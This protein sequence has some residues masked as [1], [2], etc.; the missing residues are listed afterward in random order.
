MIFYFS[1]TGNSEYVAKLIGERTGEEVINIADCV[2]KTKYHFIL[3]KGERVGFVYPVYCWGLP[4]IVK[5]FVKEVSIVKYGKHFVYSV[6]T[7]GAAT[8]SADE[9]LAKLLKAKK[10]G[11]NA[12]FGIKM[13]DNYTVAFSVKNKEKINAKNLKAMDSI[14]DMLFLVDNK[15]GGYYNHCR[16]F[17]PAAHVAHLS[18][19]IGRS[20][21]PFKASQDCIGCGKCAKGCPTQAISIELGKPV[22]KKKSCTMCLS[23]LHHCPVNAI[24]YGP[25]TKFN[26]QYVFEE[27]KCAIDEVENKQNEE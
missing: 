5:D 11:M 1:G 22:W 24:N 25:T 3:K 10:I 18:Y 27:P 4:S 16:G 23:C 26:G 17:W 15:I 13:A 9:D 8:G 19:N 6:A 14:N 2:K 12:T 7:C 20:T 21:I